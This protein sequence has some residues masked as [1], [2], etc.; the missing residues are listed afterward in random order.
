MQGQAQGHNVGVKLVEFQGGSIFRKGVQIHEE[1]I[2]QEFPV[3]IVEFIFIFGM[4]FSK[5]LFIDLLKVME[6]I[7]ALWVDAFVDDKVFPV[8]LMDEGMPTVRAAQAEGRETVAFIGRET[9]I[10]D[11]TEELAPGA[12]VLIEIDGRGLASGTGAV[13]G[14]V[15]I[16]ASGNGLNGLSVAFPPVGD[17]IFVRP[18]LI[19]GPDPGEFIDLELLILW[20]MGIIESPLSE[21]DVSADKVD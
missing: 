20:G 12:I 11:L 7:G 14:D 6:I 3:D 17:Q 2:H 18:V 21:R 16:R 19:K 10:T 4:L 1:E 5:V 8:F 15:C 13:F 9:G